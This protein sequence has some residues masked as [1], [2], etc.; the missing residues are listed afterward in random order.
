MEQKNT[1]FLKKNSMN[2][3]IH[4]RNVIHLQVFYSRWSSSST[5]PHSL[6]IEPSWSEP[7]WNTCACY[8]RIKKK[9]FNGGGSVISMIAIYSNVGSN[10]RVSCDLIFVREFGQTFQQ[11]MV[12]LH[13]GHIVGHLS[14]YWRP[15]SCLFSIRECVN[16]HNMWGPRNF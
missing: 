14:V 12:K 13:V 10:Q 8:K 7:F 5:L 15:I 2:S 9:R 1:I 3:N 16:G 11:I 6:H 4:I